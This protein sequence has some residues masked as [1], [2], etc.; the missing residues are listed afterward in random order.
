LD[1]L[2]YTDSDKSISVH[3]H[4]DIKDQVIVEVATPES[5][6]ADKEEAE[7]LLRQITKKIAGS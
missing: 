5:D 1:E 2:A 6:K 4:V 3:S 7:R